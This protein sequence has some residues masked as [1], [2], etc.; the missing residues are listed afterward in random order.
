MRTTCERRQKSASHFM[1]THHLQQCTSVNTSHSVRSHKMGWILWELIIWSNVRQSI[2][3]IPCVLVTLL[4]IFWELIIWSN[5]RQSTTA[6]PCVLVTASM[7]THHLKQCTS[8][9]FHGFLFDNVNTTWSN[10]C[11][12][13]S[14]RLLYTCSL[15]TSM[16]TR[17][18]EQCTST[19]FHAFLFDN[20]NENS[21]LEA[22]YVKAIP[23][24]LVWQCQWELMTWS[25]VHQHHSMMRSSMSM[26]MRTHDL[27]Q[28]TST[29][30]H[31]F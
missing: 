3:A 12:H 21:W 11:Q 28:C 31:V 8:A 15:S 29:P 4:P 20:V 5:V 7:R 9:P 1:R 6:I 30:F 22:M 23:C 17:H 13:H 18:L 14:M 25:N 10:V 24:V 27:K 16:R 19:P 2:P 26:S